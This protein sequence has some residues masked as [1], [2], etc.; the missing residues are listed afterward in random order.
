MNEQTVVKTIYKAERAA[1]IFNE[2]NRTVNGDDKH[3]LMHI[4][5]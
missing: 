5:P 2:R 3:F 1:N 4:G